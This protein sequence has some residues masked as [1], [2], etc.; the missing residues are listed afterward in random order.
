MVRESVAVTMGSGLSA[1]V[2]A[3][4]DDDVLVVPPVA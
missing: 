2:E 1:R 3:A 4:Q